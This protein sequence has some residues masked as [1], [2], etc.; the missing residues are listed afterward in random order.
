MADLPKINIPN[1]PKNL[2]LITFQSVINRYG[3]L[4]K[5]AR[6][7]VRINNNNNK[8]IK[9]S[10]TLSELTYLCDAAEL[11][12]KALNTADFR[13]GGPNAKYPFQ[14]QYTDMTLSFIMRN[15]MTEKLMF[16]EWMQIIN[17]TTRYEFEYKDQYATTID[18]Y[19]MSEYAQSESNLDAK[20]IYLATLKKAFPLNVNAIPLVWADENVMRLQVQFAFTDWKTPYDK[21]LTG[22]NN[23]IVGGTITRKS[24]LGLKLGE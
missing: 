14:T 7:I 13:Y 15:D 2:D 9:S 11:P 22:T 10:S 3:G 21:E 17:P 1:S 5:A 20:T 23:I 19:A 8:L 24:Y 18:I 6:F 12:G 16:D 4:A